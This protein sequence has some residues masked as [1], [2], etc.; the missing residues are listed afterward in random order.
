MR[1][2]DGLKLSW[3]NNVAFK[4]NV[5]LKVTLKVSTTVYNLSLVIQ[6][7][8]SEG[9]MSIKCTRLVDVLV[10]TVHNYM[11]FAPLMWWV[12]AAR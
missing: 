5:T 2:S 8:K 4:R 7:S 9:E 11:N 10:V 1:S 6:T 12:T 3:S